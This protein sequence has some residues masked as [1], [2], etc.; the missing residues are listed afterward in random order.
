MGEAPLKVVCVTGGQLGECGVDGDTWDLPMSLEAIC[1]RLGRYLKPVR[2]RP[3]SFSWRGVAAERERMS[4]V[5]TWVLAQDG[6]FYEEPVVRGDGWFLCFDDDDPPELVMQCRLVG[7]MRKRGANVVEAAG[8]ILREAGV[9]FS[10]IKYSGVAG[11]IFGGQFKQAASVWLM[12]NG[13][14]PVPANFD[15]KLTADEMRAYVQ[16][17]GCVYYS[18]DLDIRPPRRKRTA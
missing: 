16:R 4:L 7:Q 3:L 2:L 9:A 8:R 17:R 5:G 11:R 14:I 15:Q 12:V 18:F 1:A 10:D 13:P 6:N